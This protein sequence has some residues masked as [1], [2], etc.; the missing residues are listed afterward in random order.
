LS[1]LAD[2]RVERVAVVERL[3]R[4]PAS[5]VKIEAGEETAAL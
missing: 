3:A 2:G 1:V 5:A 4:R